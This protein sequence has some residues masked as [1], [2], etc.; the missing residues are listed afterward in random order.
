MGYGRNGGATMPHDDMRVDTD[1]VDIQL[2]EGR[3]D[4]NGS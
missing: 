4:G 1:S 3:D 2:L